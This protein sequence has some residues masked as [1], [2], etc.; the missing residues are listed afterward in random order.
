M[1]NYC[2]KDSMARD[3]CEPRVI[4][5][6]APWEGGHWTDGLTQSV[7]RLRCILTGLTIHRC[8]HNAIMDPGQHWWA[9]D[10]LLILIASLRE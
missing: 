3:D 6:T 9:Q 4:G 2:A 1:A 10:R 8:I 7:M 5:S